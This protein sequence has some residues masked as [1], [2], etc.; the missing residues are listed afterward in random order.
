M[1]LTRSPLGT[2]QCCHQVGLA[3]LACVKHAAS[4]RPEPG[5]NSPSEIVE[6]LRHTYRS[7]QA[8]GFALVRNSMPLRGIEAHHPRETSSQGW[9]IPGTKPRYRCAGSSVSPDVPSTVARD[10]HVELMLSV[11]AP[12]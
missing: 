12:F 3:R 5:S 6:L 8:K 9:A 11:L 2:T 1:L 4:V 7:R 10:S